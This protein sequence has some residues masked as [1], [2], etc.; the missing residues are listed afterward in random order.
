MGNYVEEGLS[1]GEAVKYIARLSLYKYWLNFLLGGL[2]LFGSLSLLFKAFIVPS[3]GHAAGAITGMSM[4]VVL[5]LALAVFLWPFLARRRTELAITNKRLIAKFGL[6]S[7]QS[8]EIRL[9]KIE[10]V[11]VKQGLLGRILDYGD[12][13]VTGTGST[14]DPIRNISSPL[15]FRTS[16]NQAMEPSDAS[17]E[18]DATASRMA[19][20]ERS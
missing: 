8:I 13:V 9:G 3:N 14:F 7:T 6:V 18:P 20:I 1:P 4:G 15:A 19:A 11:R 2:M 16:L 12:I 5:L 10:S 17:R